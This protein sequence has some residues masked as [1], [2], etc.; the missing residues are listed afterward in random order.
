MGY[1]APCWTPLPMNLS[2]NWRNIL[3]ILD[4]LV[5]IDC[6]RSCHFDN[7]RCIQWRKCPQNETGVWVGDL[8]Y[9]CEG[10]WADMYRDPHVKDK[11]VSRPSYL[12]HGDPHTRERRSFILRWAPVLPP[13]TIQMASRGLSVSKYFD[14]GLVNGKA[15]GGRKDI[16]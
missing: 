2:P 7:L 10:H 9:S 1:I 13:A 8:N 11:T 3:W 4:V 12:E 5:D 15:L 6:T 14:K 16:Y